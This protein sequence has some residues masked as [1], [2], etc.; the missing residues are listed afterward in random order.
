MMLASCEGPIEM[1]ETIFIPDESDKNLPAYTEWGYNS[2]G[3]MYERMYFYSTKNVIPCK[4]IMQNGMITFTLSGRFGSTNSSWGNEN[5]TLYFSFPVNEPMTNYKDLL[6]LHQKHIDLTD[7]SCNLMMMRNSNTEDIS[8][9]SGDL[10]FK[11]V[12]LLRINEQ[13]NRVIL[14]GTFELTFLRNKL[15]EILSK[16]RFDVGIPYLFVLP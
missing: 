15:P 2:F 16:G 1:E 12:Q 6:S 3:A 7:P 5:M 9:L 4:I 13:E 11:R 14:S 10:F 8:L